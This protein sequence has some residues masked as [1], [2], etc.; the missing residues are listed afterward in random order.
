MA[1]IA[2]AIISPSLRT[3]NH[4]GDAFDAARICRGGINLDGATRR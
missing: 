3:F 1:T 4:A 2:V